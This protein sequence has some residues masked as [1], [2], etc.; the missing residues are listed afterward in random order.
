MKDQDQKLGNQA[1]E[2]TNCDFKYIFWYNLHNQCKAATN[3]IPC[4]ANKN[5][6]TVL[7]VK[8][9]ILQAS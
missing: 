2:E 3:Y 4:T 5:I 8:I 1:G 6:Y 9:Q 7:Y